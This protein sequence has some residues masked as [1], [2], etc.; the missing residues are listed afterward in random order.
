MIN[1]VFK[2]RLTAPLFH[3]L[4]FPEKEIASLSEL[5][6]KHVLFVMSYGGPQEKKWANFL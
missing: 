5:T 3:L 4:P 6:L 1:G 2:A